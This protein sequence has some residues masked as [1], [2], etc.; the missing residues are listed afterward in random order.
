MCPLGLPAEG[1]PSE[2]WGWWTEGNAQLPSKNDPRE[3]LTILIVEDDPVIRMSIA[4]H[5][6]DC[7]F[8]ILEAGSAPD[9]IG[10]LHAAKVD[11]VFT[12]VRMPGAID[13]FGL[14]RWV[15]ANRP[16]IPV[17]L[18]SGNAQKD[19]V[20]RELCEENRFFTKPYDF[21]EVAGYI[22]SAV[23]QRSA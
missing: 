16:G 1:T 8:K 13:G 5:L 6:R 19:D 18:A 15:R 20:E 23:L 2:A 4:G 14:A 10:R 17:F 12:D 3:A 22:R 7:G 11:L 9:A 21:A